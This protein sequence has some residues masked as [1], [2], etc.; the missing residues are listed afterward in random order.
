[1]RLVTTTRVIA[2]PR[3]ILRATRACPYSQMMGSLSTYGVIVFL[4]NT[5]IA[6]LMGA[7]SSNFSNNL[8]S[9]LGPILALFGEKVTKQFMAGS[10]GWADKIMFAMVCKPVSPFS[11]SSKVYFIHSHI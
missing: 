11:F 2:T 8:F 10:T 4:M 5:P 1:M 3:S 9:D 7:G 6:A